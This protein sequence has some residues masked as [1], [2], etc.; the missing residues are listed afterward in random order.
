MSDYVYLKNLNGQQIKPVTDLA[1]INMT[2]TN[3]IGVSTVNGGTIGIIDG[4]IESAYYTEM[5]DPAV[6]AANVSSA[7]V[8]GGTAVAIL[9]AYTVASAVDTAA[10]SQQKVPSEK[11]V[12][13][14]LNN[15]VVSGVSYYAGTGINIDQ[16][17]TV[18]VA[19]VPQSS[20]AGLET[21]LTGINTAVAAK[22]DAISAGYRMS[23]D[24]TTL[25][26]KRYFDIES[27]TSATIT[28]QA[29][30][31]YKI[32]ATTSQKTLVA[33]TF[34]ANS[35][36]LEGHAEIFVANT[37]YITTGSNV[38]LADPLELNAV[39]NC[40]IRF[41]DGIA[42][43]S[44]EDHVAGYVVSVASGT[45]ANTMYAAL[46][47][48]TNEYVSVDAS[49]DGT[50]IDAGAA[51]STTDKHF[52]GNG[53]SN[54][55]VEGSFTVGTELTVMNCTFKP[56]VVAG[57]GTFT[58]G[59]AV[60][61]LN[62]NI[63]ASPV[64][65]TGGVV[66]D[67]GVTLID[68][69]GGSN[70]VDPRAYAAINSDGTT[71]PAHYV[72]GYAQGTTQG[73]SNYVAIVLENNVISKVSALDK[74]KMACHERR[75][76][77]M[78]DL[79]TRHINYYLNPEDLTKKLDG[80]PAVLDGTDG[81]VMTEFM[82]S[83]YLNIQM[84][85]QNDT[86]VR[87][88]ILMS[89]Y[90]FSYTDSNNVVHT[91]AYHDSFKISPTGD[92]VRPQYMGYYQASTAV[93]GGV[94]K[95][96]SVSSTASKYVYP[97]VSLRLGP[98]SA[99]SPT[100]DSFLV[101]A[102]NNGGTICNEL[103]YEWLFHL[104]VADKLTVNTQSVSLGFCYAAN[105]SWSTIYPRACGYTNEV[106]NF[107]GGQTLA[108]ARD[109]DMRALW[110]GCSITTGGNVYAAAPDHCV[111]TTDATTGA[112]SVSAY[113]WQWR[114][115]SSTAYSYVYTKGSVGMPT[116]SAK[117]YTDNACTTGEAS[118]TAVNTG[119]AQSNRVTSCK[120]FIEN[121]WSSIWQ[122]LAGFAPFVTG[123]TLG[124]FGTTS[125]NRYKE[126]LL[127]TTSQIGSD[128]AA[129]GGNA[130]IKWTAHSWPQASNYVTTWNMDTFLPITA[131]STNVM[132]DY[133]Y[134]HATNSNP[135]AGFRGGFALYTSAGGLGCVGVYPAVG[136][137]GGYVGARLAA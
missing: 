70:G 84:T 51:V 104:F 9:G 137:A 112:R 4:Y 82:P 124:Y 3:G 49:L 100:Q 40:T 110:N 74:T 86:T 117:C 115:D 29:G 14:A 111:Y 128:I 119:T 15:V 8:D 37:G 103:H 126:I 22:Q 23:L 108:D 113:G 96:R 52:V 50:I 95:L 78:D 102:E 106:T 33:E 38:V 58:I 43:I 44:V 10:P 97:T 41:H 45:A 85:P 60:L 88:C 13:D 64:S 83:Y 11:A 89:R 101:R 32:T 116:T 109:N 75:I 66:V 21:T 92:E 19:N 53:T 136:Y 59:D 18:S 107:Y 57:V 27:P 68:A 31:A 56:E 79:A 87:N 36:G 90:P 73:T 77:V 12:V 54:T 61:D 71:E 2:T 130:A 24:G 118:I 34:D 55:T 26:Q 123:S 72:Y 5:A 93:V 125:T 134:T 105:A 62:G 35:F 132:Q 121:P 80:T 131:T 65:P 133:F 67:A 127:T 76:C 91:A 42:I 47:N 28:L 1:A 114:P 122:N 46:A 120:Y 48:T 17:H 63:I 69:E 129:S 135:R 20:V 6:G 16:G 25:N 7:Y 94:N 39:N 81:D 98:S 99:S 30:H